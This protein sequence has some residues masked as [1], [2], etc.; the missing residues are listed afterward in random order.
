MIHYIKY[1]AGRVDARLATGL[2]NLEEVTGGRHHNDF[3]AV[4][5]GGAITNVLH[6]EELEGADFD[7]AYD[8][9]LVDQITRAAPGGSPG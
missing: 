5:G 2:T 4:G 3:R 8:L 7:N 9:E 6:S 1:G